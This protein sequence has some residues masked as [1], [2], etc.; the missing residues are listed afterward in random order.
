MSDEL[1]AYIRQQLYLESVKVN[2]TNKFDETVTQIEAA[3]AI[4]IARIGYDKISEMSKA[5]LNK[6]VSQMTA[7]LSV[8][9]NTSTRVVTSAMKRLMNADTV[10]T[11]SLASWLSGKAKSRFHVVGSRLWATINNAPIGGTGQEPKNILSNFFSS[12]GAKI[13]SRLKQG[14]AEGWTPREL[15]TNIIGSSN[16]QFNNGVLKGIKNQFGAAISTWIQHISSFVSQAVNSIFYDR[17]QWVSVIDDRTT[18]ICRERDGNVYEYGNG[19]RPP[20]HYRCRAKTIPMVSEQPVPMPT[21]SVWVNQQPPEVR[22][23]IE[24]YY[25]VKAQGSTRLNPVRPMSIDE[26]KEKVNTMLTGIKKG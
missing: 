1:D 21:F 26:Y 24:K 16:Y 12:A 11:T 22:R 14:W 5:A 19:P 8:I 18:A 13:V 15:L 6:L 20:A 23:D 9:F 4:I 7:K 3:V 2:E 17:Y 10:V 25:G